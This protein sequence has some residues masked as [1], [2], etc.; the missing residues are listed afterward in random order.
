MDYVLVAYLAASRSAL[1]YAVGEWARIWPLQTL[2]RSLGAYFVRR[3]SGDPLYRRVLARYV[4][5]ATTGGVVQAVYPEGNLSRGGAYVH[6]PRQDRDYEVIAPYLADALR[7]SG[8]GP[9]AGPFSRRTAPPRTPAGPSVMSCHSHLS[10]TWIWSTA[11]IP[12]SSSSAPRERSRSLGA[13]RLSASSSRRRRRRTWVKCLA[14]R[15]LVALQAVLA[16]DEMNRVHRRQT[17]G[18]RVPRPGPGGIASNG[19]CARP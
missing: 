14:S 1:S 17:V 4:Q 2:I 15:Q 10:A 3:R 8:A 18:S 11:F 13:D 16:L 7:V 5:A 19:S 6:I 12:G 9:P